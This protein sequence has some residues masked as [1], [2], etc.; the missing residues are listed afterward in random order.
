MPNKIRFTPLYSGGP[1]YLKNHAM[2]VVLDL[3]GM[4]P[5]TL[6]LPALLEHDK[7]KL[8]GIL[9]EVELEK[10]G[11][12]VRLNAFGRLSPPGALGAD[13]AQ[14][15]E[16][17]F[18]DGYVWE[19]SVRIYPP[20]KLDWDFVPEGKETVINGRFLCGP[21]KVLRH[22]KILEG[23][24]V[25]V[26]AD[27]ENHA[28]IAA[29]AG[30]CRFFL[31]ENSMDPKLKEFLLAAGIKIE[32]CT[33][34]QLAIAERLFA[35]MNAST[36]NADP[37]K[38]DV[39][40]SEGDPQEDPPK[41]DVSASEGDLQEDPPKDDVSAS[42][43]DPQ[44]EPQED[45]GVAASA[46]KGDPP[47]SRLPRGKVSRST[48]GHPDI[49]D[50][51][52]VALASSLR[53]DMGDDSHGVKA[54]GSF[55]EAAMNEGLAAKWRGL[56]L[57]DVFV[58][59]YE[60]RT[61]TRLRTGLPGGFGATCFKMMK[62]D[63][64]DGVAASGS[65]ST[66]KPLVI[67]ENVMNMTF[68]E[69]YDSFQGVAEKICDV[70]TNPDLKKQKYVTFD[71]SGN[72]EKVPMGGELP[73]V[74]LVD[75]EIE[76][77]AFTWAMLMT[78][79]EEMILNDMLDAFS[80]T[81]HKIGVKLKKLR[82]QCLFQTA[83]ADLATMC[84]TARGN[85]IDTPLSIK[86]YDKASESLSMMETIGSTRANIEFTEYEGKYVLTPRG[87]YPTARTLYRD[88]K[89]DLVGIA[90][91]ELESNPHV[92]LYEPITSS[93]FGSRGYFSTDTHWAMLADP[94]IC[95]AFVISYLKGEERPRIE[96]FPTPPNVLGR[97]W[98]A[99][100][101][102]GIQKGDYR[103]IVYSDGTGT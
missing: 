6:P 72:M 46:G 80:R 71:I 29:S 42:E 57:R 69:G 93:Y 54:S 9:E 27:P 78:L 4:E 13:V 95:P 68:R 77:Q 36:T 60:Q 67:L 23:S 14:Y 26:G 62:E 70:T 84:T 94:K 18:K 49:N 25:A 81:P 7:D 65:F 20:S 10:I 64:S 85:L 30:V 21:L 47:A 66:I 103:G 58:A 48:S 34:D 52:S 45:D 73:H 63:E 12:A 22:W 76:T 28:G 88:T 37:P 96:N 33:P 92:G 83:S 35:A 50:V 61:R 3:Q 79:E 32:E 19:C 40:A 1:L 53:L 11:D 39:S 8:C 86:G 5:P 56:G 97:T 38:D 101:R 31:E 82:D 91:A 16:Q 59:A 75:D 102:F 87:L 98:R 74:T 99:V 15:V 43:G 51:M 2:P 90:G 55:T 24:F 17:S 44:K 41:D 100:W 89:C